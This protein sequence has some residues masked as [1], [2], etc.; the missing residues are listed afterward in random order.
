MGGL[1]SLLGM[2]P[3]MGGKIRAEDIP[4]EKAV[5]RIESI[6]LSMTNEE[7]EKPSI[8]NPSRKNRIAKGAGVDISE[9]NRL[10]KQFE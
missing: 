5:K 2:I 8:I 4:D 10:M 1:T 6:I 7:R 3:G 9:V